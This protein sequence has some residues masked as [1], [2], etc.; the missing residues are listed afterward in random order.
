MCIYNRLTGNNVQFS[1]LVHYAGGKAKFYP[2]VQKVWDFYVDQSIVKQA[3]VPFLGGGSDMTNISPRIMGK[4]ETMI[5]NDYNP[6][7]CGVNINI[8]TIVTN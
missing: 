3:L 1:T 2:E 4:V 5:V 6:V 8:Q 7:I